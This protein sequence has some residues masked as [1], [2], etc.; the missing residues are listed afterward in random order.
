MRAIPLAVLA[1]LAVSAVLVPRTVLPSHAA[2]A[3]GPTELRIEL[4]SDGAWSWF[5]DPRA[6][7]RGDTLVAA[8][9]T[10]D[11]RLQ[12]GT[13][14]LDTGGVSLFDVVP[15]FE[16][17]DHS[18]PILW[19]TSDGRYSAFYSIHAG[20][21]TFLMY[22]VTTRPGDLSSWS[23]ERTVGTNT[24]GF[25]GA[26]YP[27]LIP[28]HGASD[29]LLA[30][31]RGGN[32]NPTCTRLWYDGGRA[33]WGF[34]GAKAL[35]LCASERP[36]AKYAFDGAGR[37]GV[38]FTD[39]HPRETGNNLY[40]VSLTWPQE[41]GAAFRRADGGMIR[42]LASGP[43]A[44][45]EA[46]LVF[47]RTAAPEGVGD[48]CWVW[49]VAFDASDHPVVAYSTFLSRGAHQYHLARHD[50]TLWEDQLLVADAGGSIADT[51]QGYREYYYS[52]GMALDHADPGTVYMSLPNESGGWDLA[53]WKTEDGGLSWSMRSI[54]TGAQ[55]KNVRPVVPR[56][57]PAGTEMVAWMSGQYDYYTTYR[58]AIRLW[59]L[60]AGPTP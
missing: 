23:P 29:T 32:W 57:H 21:S 52:G 33:V 37:V 22:R 50:G 59:A 31:W 49:D 20:A 38:A 55:E 24:P 6:S 18:H 15:D 45:A 30:F 51:T 10:G 7:C 41:G 39:G 3:P 34:D 42:S 13:C 16:G 26:T 60:R 28:L 25:G 48:N 58:T 36:Y 14:D 11:G 2:S 27:N 46:E 53:Q 40:Y 5:S 43:L 8:W 47:D 4:T 12:A 1:T 44:A 17:D 9:V 19:R 54:T 35:I 56:D